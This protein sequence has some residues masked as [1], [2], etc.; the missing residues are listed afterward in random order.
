MI[1]Q[2]LT[3]A[4]LT[5]SILQFFCLGQTRTVAPVPI[6]YKKAVPKSVAGLMPRGAKSLFWGTFSNGKNAAPKAIH[7]FAVNSKAQFVND[8][9]KR[10][11]NGYHLT[12]DLFENRNH[13]WAR[14]NRVPLGYR[15]SLWGPLLVSAD[16][17]W[18]DKQ[19]QMPLLSLRCFTKDGYWP[20]I[21]VGDAIFLSF[22]GDW[23][24]Q[25]T[26]QSKIYGDSNSGSSDYSFRRTGNQTLEVEEND[27]SM[28]VGKDANGNEIMALIYFRWNYAKRKFIV[29]PETAPMLG[30]SIKGTSMWKP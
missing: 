28:N 3:F 22:A 15:S 21:P 7:L 2:S 9:K 4:V 30:E 11:F 19:R 6:P 18:I 1:F 5:L 24:S 25:P 23:K 13:K 14:I 12:L 27:G 20:N 10:K 16:F 26:L 17:I 29:T 8:V